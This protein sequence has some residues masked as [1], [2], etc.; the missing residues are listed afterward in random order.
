[1]SEPSE[2]VIID[3]QVYLTLKKTSDFHKANCIK[4]KNPENPDLYN[5]AIAKK[6]GGSIQPFQPNCRGDCPNEGRYN[7]IRYVIKAQKN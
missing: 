2:K 5:D 6:G 1:M 3:K 7:N 4:P